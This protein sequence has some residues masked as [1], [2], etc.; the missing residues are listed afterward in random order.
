MVIVNMSKII[1]IYDNNKVSEYKYDI[2]EDTIIYHFSFNSS[3]KVLVNIMKENVSLYYYYN[4]INYDDNEYKIRI[5]HNKSNTSSYVFNH[6]VNINDN[7]LHYWVDGFVPKSSNNCNCNQ[8][9]QI[10][11][12]NNGKSKIWPNLLIDNYDV[13]ANHAAYIGKFREDYLFYLMSRGINKK[14]AYKL[15]IRSL[16][17]FSDSIDMNKIK[18]FTDEID[19]L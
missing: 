5:N 4:N 17:L 15:L 16:L 3:S 19:K 12:I 14:S 13:D 2:L 8:Y 1:Y 9:N 10:I 7:K 6:G 18:Y 11:N